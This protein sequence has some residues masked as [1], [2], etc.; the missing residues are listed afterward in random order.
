[1]LKL[2]DS[3]PMA[4]MLSG[5]TMEFTFKGDL[6]KTAI[7]VGMMM[8]LNVIMDNKNEKGLMLMSIPMAGKNIGVE[9]TPEDLK[10]MKE[11]QKVNQA[12][13]QIEYFKKGKKKIAGYKC[14][15]A[16]ATMSGLPE[17]IT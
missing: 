15:K 17:P 3:N 16:V 5:A 7:N 2:D 8:S 14:Y 9:M 11:D 10:K 1:E 4:S 12:K 6:S 13:A